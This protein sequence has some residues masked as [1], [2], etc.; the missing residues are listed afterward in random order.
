MPWKYYNKSIRIPVKKAKQFLLIKAL[1][2][3]GSSKDTNS[4]KIL[5]LPGYIFPHSSDYRCGRIVVK[6]RSLVDN[7]IGVEFD[8]KFDS[9]SLI[10]NKLQICGDLEFKFVISA[11]KNLVNSILAC[12]YSVEDIQTETFNLKMKNK[13][14]SYFYGDYYYKECYFA[15][16]ESV[17]NIVFEDIQDY[18]NE[19][20]PQW[21]IFS[22]QCESNNIRSFHESF[23]THIRKKSKNAKKGL[24]EF[25]V[26][27]GF[28]G[29]Y[30][31]N[32]V[33]YV[34]F[35]KNNIKKGFKG[36]PII[37][38]PVQMCDTLSISMR[39]ILFLFVL[40]D[41]KDYIEDINEVLIK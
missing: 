38:A 15:I 7:P 32:Q 1:L 2:A 20:H 19:K 21:E 25:C 6:A 39:N 28:S 5:E 18:I 29:L 13:V 36:M 37:K 12:Q 22:W 4:I 3:S 10:V 11:F 33:E 9:E 27:N 35:I 17:L 16:Q 40:N 14:D 34:N 31:E 26:I 24:K 23:F 30:R 8:Y 41:G